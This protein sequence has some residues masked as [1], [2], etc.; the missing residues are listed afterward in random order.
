MTA[1][2]L[3][4]MPS[5]WVLTSLH[6]SVTA[7]SVMHLLGLIEAAHPVVPLG[8]LFMCRGGSPE[9][10]SQATQAKAARARASLLLC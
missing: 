7:L 8:L 4:E 5:R 6:M 10:G 9:V 1:R 3:G 2:L